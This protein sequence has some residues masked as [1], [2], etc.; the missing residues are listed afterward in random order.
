MTIKNWKRHL[1]QITAVT[2]TL[3]LTE[4]NY[5]EMQLTHLCMKQHTFITQKLVECVSKIA[6]VTLATKL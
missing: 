2:G 4:A 6:F 5:G 1:S 3:K